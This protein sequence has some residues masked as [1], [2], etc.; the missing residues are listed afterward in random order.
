MTCHA[1]PVT[2][3]VT[4]TVTDLR[5]ELERFEAE[6]RRAGLKETTVR[7]YVDRSA[8]FVRWLAG[9]Y[10]FQGPQGG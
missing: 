5:Q 2:E 6:A 1:V 7:T 8:I 3:T 4:W 10:Q 9:D